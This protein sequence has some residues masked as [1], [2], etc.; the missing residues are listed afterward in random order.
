M[1]GM[2]P[3]IRLGGASVLSAPVLLVMV[4]AA[5]EI[6]SSADS[7]IESD[8]GDLREGEPIRILSPAVV[9]SDAFDVLDAMV[10]S[11]ERVLSVL[12]CDVSVEVHSGQVAVLTDVW[13]LIDALGRLA[14]VGE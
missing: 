7:G 1:L 5:P 11:S 10:C 12:V 2:R 14:V 9:V 8:G 6:G 4:E 13:L 3:P